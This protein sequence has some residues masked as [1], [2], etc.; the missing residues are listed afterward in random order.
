MIE[1]ASSMKDLVKT[2]KPCCLTKLISENENLLEQSICECD[3]SLVNALH[4][5]KPEFKQYDKS[6][7]KIGKGIKISRDRSCF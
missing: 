4:S 1:V 6:N 7:C 5:L 3:R 2:K